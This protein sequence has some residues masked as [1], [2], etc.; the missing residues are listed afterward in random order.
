ML[1]VLIITL[2]MLT[3]SINQ[4]LASDIPSC[5]PNMAGVHDMSM[6]DTANDDMCMKEECSSHCICLTASYCQAVLLDYAPITS[7]VML[8][9]TTIPLVLRPQNQFLSYLFKPPILI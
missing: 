6:S 7:V 2:S 5:Q 3:M 9:N 8:D 4:V 1:R